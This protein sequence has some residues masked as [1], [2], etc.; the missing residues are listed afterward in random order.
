MDVF[1]S[2]PRLGSPYGDPTRQAVDALRGYGYQLYAS[3]LAW[4]GLADGEL[5][6]LEVAEDYSVI[7]RQAL[8]GTQVKDTAA[9]GKIT[10]QS[11]D[12][13]SAI[14][15][16]VDMVAR[17]H[18]RVVSLHYLT[19]AEIGLERRKDQRVDNRSALHYWRQ[20][21]AGADVAP[22]RNLLEALDLKPATK[23]YVLARNDELLRSDLLARIHWHC[24]ASSFEELREELESGLIEF[25]ASARRLS[26][27]VAKNLLPA[28]VERLL[29][30][31]TSKS[32]RQL[33][34]ADLLSLV[35]SV[36]MVSV[37]VDQLA[38]AFS[39]SGGAFTRTSLLVS[40]SELPL[41]ALVAPRKEL[42]AKVD[43]VRCRTGIAIAT[44]ATG[45]GKTLV[46][47][48][49]ASATNGHWV[50]VDFRDLGPGET[51]SRLSVALGELA[52]R[53]PVHVILDDL[54]EIDHPAVRDAFLRLMTSLRRRDATAIV[55]TYRAPTPATQHL[56]SPQES[57]VV[58]VP[59][60]SD[61]EVSAL[62][63]SIGGD[64]KYADPVYRAA[65]LGH[66][67]LTM[68]I[69]LHLSA[70][71]WSRASVAALLGGGLQAE[72]GAERRAM[73]QRL[74]A[75]IPVDAQSLFFRTSL[76][77][78]TFNRGLAMTLGEV[79]PPVSRT[80]L[81]LD[82][83]VGAWIEPMYGDRLRVS[84][85]L[86]GAGLEVF[87]PGEC[88]AIHRCIADVLISS[89]TL[90]V[91]DAGTA[92]RHALKSEE[93]ALVVAFAD[94][95]IR[96]NAETLELV[97]PFLGELGSFQT[98]IPIFPA[99]LFASVMMRF[100]QLLSLLPYGS[101]ARAQQ[102]WEALERERV[103]IKGQVLFEGSILSK[104]LV[105]ERAGA[106]FP[107]WIELLL[108]FD[109]L[110]ETDVRLAEIS[111]GFQ[112]QS[113]GNP[114]VTG[115]LFASQMRNITTVA[116]FRALLER[117]DQEPAALR[118]R[119]FSS[120]QPGRGDLSI[121]VTHPW[122][123]ES[124][125]EGFD[126]E[127]AAGQYSACADIAIR[128][129]N[130]ALAIRCSIA[131]SI[132]LDES[133]DDAERAFA[134]L[135]D[136]ERRFGFDIALVRARAKIHWRRRDHSAALPLLAT[137]A[138]AGGQDAIERAYIAREAGIS[139]A[140]LGNWAEAEHWFEKAQTE[141]SDLKLPS[142]RAMAI[143][144]L[145][146]T[147]HAAFCDG[148]A[149]VA[150]VKL[151]EALA[152]L[153]TINP[154]GT[155][156][157]VYCHRVIRH[158]VLWVFNELTH[159]VPAEVQDI[160]YAPGCASNLD[161]PE[162][163]RSH[164]LGDIDFAYY[165]LADADEALTRP[166]GFHLEFRRALLKGP[167]LSSEISRI[168]SAGRKAIVSHDAT[169]FVPL[170]R[171]HAAMAAILAAGGGRDHG[172][173]LQN[174]ERGL[175][176][177]A[178]I[179]NDADPELLRGGEDMLL[180]FAIAAALAGSFDAVDTVIQAGLGSPEIACLHP[181][182]ERMAGR[183]NTI[184]TDRQGA[185]LAVDS[186]RRDATGEPVLFWWAGAWMLFHVRASKLRS[187]VA[188]PLVSWI[189]DKWSYLAGEG[190]FRLAAPN[191]NVPPIEVILSACDRSLANAARLLLAAVPAASIRIRADVRE[192]LELLANGDH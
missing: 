18:T 152:Q 120:F 23:A 172:Q 8:A 92:M 29:Q 94:S 71:T 102:C 70:A 170:L 122:L 116:A 76:I 124:R 160:R 97:A 128:W 186:L 74:V 142:V 32:S 67:Q 57:P 100:A 166:T 140:E 65:S 110:A 151:R 72:M 138:R 7:T 136:A 37:P 22:L 121:L 127:A 164:P 9:S 145:A 43:A 119:L 135:S 59:Y 26:S 156:A 162:S 41:P 24:G 183:L 114:H 158:A 52:S 180:S 185:A 60:F 38:A 33:R 1:D 81:A 61:G 126:W 25:A 184:S 35:D 130:P 27:Q 181:L 83:L 5:L 13:R 105:Q 131:Q 78:G 98:D 137:A 112:S 21:A 91:I 163:I 134:C 191:V 173:Q 125:A 133:G 96:C 42:V 169:D 104:L 103:D 50:I 45:V 17:N 188:E 20:A 176:P 28:M 63:S 106:L 89:R 44:A 39:G 153:P 40:T 84:P 73:R 177:L 3:G 139:A 36:S 132:C 99:N 147:A 118:E 101:V 12:V 141:A 31:A 192:N 182:L 68:A 15:N 77:G 174:P 80:G 2:G 49:A 150:V 14:D 85:L 75:A 95:V 143:G 48:L 165:M 54:N 108:R 82:R 90:S 58:E 4:V 149:D 30:T 157:E 87:A 47:R 69:L 111:R 79:A 66:P 55:T 148:R 171:H 175:V 64:L 189:F 16:F 34:R 46:A 123:K 129:K 146:D 88:R 167:I 115:V 6:H 53:P 113:G 159:S 179:D 62:V 19:T 11:A 117:L 51:A 144:L 178:V 107:S 155:L 190:R 86:E 10:L 109:R 161:P 154:D 56:L 168:I 93:A 187:G